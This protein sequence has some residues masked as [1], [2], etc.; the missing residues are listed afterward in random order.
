MTLLFRTRLPVWVLLAALALACGGRRGIDDPTAPPADYLRRLVLVL[1]RPD[2]R[3]AA[4]VDI[5][6][7]TEPPTRLVSPAGGSGRTDGRGRLELV[8][9]PPPRYDQAALAGGDIIVDF[10]V[11]ARLTLGGALTRDIDD[12]E[13]FARYA[14]PLYQGLNRDPEPGPTPVVITLP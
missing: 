7:E 3:P 2:F 13:T 1:E 8:F 14:D 5:S 4:G 12:R 10:P 11:R 9:A 6:V